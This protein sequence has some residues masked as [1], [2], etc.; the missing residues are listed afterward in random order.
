MARTWYW[1]LWP[2]KCTECRST[3]LPIPIRYQLTSSPTC[4]VRPCRFPNIL[5]LIAEGN[6]H[7]FI[8][9]QD[10]LHQ[11]LFHRKEVFKV[12]VLSCAKLLPLC[13]TLCS[14]A[15]PLSLGFSRR[16]HW[17]GLPCPPPGGLPDPGIKPMSRTSSALAGGVFAASATWEA[18]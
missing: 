8:A 15:A 9:F 17:S 12:N 6:I 13:L 4:I 18:P 7:V 2:W 1:K 11:Q 10:I 3:S 16:E 14:P 5:P